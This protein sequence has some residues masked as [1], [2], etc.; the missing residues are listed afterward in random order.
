MSRKYRPHKRRRSQAVT[1]VEEPGEQ[2]GANDEQ[3]A[4]SGEPMEVDISDSSQPA[5]GSV[6]DQMAEQPAEPDEE[7][8]RK[9]E[10]WEAFQEEHHEGMFP[11]DFSV[12]RSVRFMR[13]FFSQF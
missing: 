4:D 3:D 7:L 10:I 12:R 2:D 11:R 5:A 8:K 1:L 13:W 9:Q 6:Q